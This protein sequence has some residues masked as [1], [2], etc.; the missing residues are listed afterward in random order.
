MINFNFF[1][2][3]HVVCGAI[4]SLQDYN[5]RRS[6]ICRTKTLNDLSILFCADVVTTELYLIYL[7]TALLYLRQSTG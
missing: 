4:L 3:I 7:E 5:G 6:A 1:R 2:I